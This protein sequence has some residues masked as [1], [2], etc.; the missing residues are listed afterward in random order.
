MST[1]KQESKT[2]ESYATSDEQH[3][4]RKM[5][6]GSTGTTNQDAVDEV[7]DNA[8]G[9]NATIIDLEF[10]KNKLNLIFNNGTPMT[11]DDRG[12]YLTL[13]TRCKKVI[14]TVTP[15]KRKGM[16]GIGEA[17]SRGRLA[18]QGIQTTTTKTEDGACH[19]VEIDLKG[20]TA[21]DYMHPQ[22]WTGSQNTS[23]EDNTLRPKWKKIETADHEKYKTGVTKEYTGEDLKQ[24]FELS[25]T[26][27]HIADKYERNIGLSLKI[28]VKWNNKEYVVPLIYND[29]KWDKKTY[30]L[31]VYS[32]LIEFTM[33]NK[34]Q[35]ISKGKNGMWRNSKA[36]SNSCAESKEDAVGTLTFTVKIPKKSENC[37]KGNGVN[38]VIDWFNEC[39][40]EAFTD[41]ISERDNKLYLKCGNNEVFKDLN[42]IKGKSKQ[43]A[44]TSTLL[45]FNKGLSISMDNMKLA[46]NN[47]DLGLATKSLTEAGSITARAFRLDLNFNSDQ[48]IIKP[49]E[50]KNVLTVPSEVT[51]AL[52]TIVKYEAGKINTE[53]KKQRKSR[54]KVE[55]A[56]K[57]VT[58]VADNAAFAAHVAK[59]KADEI[60]NSTINNNTSPGEQKEDTSEKSDNS[61]DKSTVPTSQKRFV[62]K[63]DYRNRVETYLKQFEEDDVPVDPYNLMKISEN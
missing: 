48:E 18:G 1:N 34:R 25:D 57:V 41:N 15:K 50:N 24:N 22:C 13:D 6:K 2:D 3:R 39:L 32:D 47:F 58:L 37:P 21:E 52:N 42:E 10:N 33:D 51:K 12:R 31:T 28:N 63:T 60:R 30:T 4:L 14:G 23:G 27:F 8:I 62:T 55:N 56:A 53:I 35:T 38:P 9:E 5:I 36:A 40:S 7:F 17:F 46:T 19:Q 16:H 11:R 45:E 61:K 54:N 20:M 43:T 44:M 59:A 49:Q 26:V 29:D